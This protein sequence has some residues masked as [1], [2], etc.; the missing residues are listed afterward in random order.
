MEPLVTAAEMRECDALAIKKFRMPGVA[1]MENA[2]RGVAM[3]IEKHF[4]SQRG[5]TIFIFCGKGNNGGD[6]FVAGRHLLNCGA[7]VVIIV[8][9]RIR[10]VRGDAKIHLDVAKKIAS[11]NNGQ[12]LRIIEF[13]STQQLSRIGK[14]NIIVDALFG[15]GFSGEVKKPYREV[16]QW[17]NASG[18]PLVAVD[19]PS[20]VNA[21]NGETASIAVRASLTVTMGLK[22]IGLVVG[23]GLECTGAIVVEDIGVRESILKSRKFRTFLVQQRDVQEILPRR[24]IDAHKHSVGKVFVLAGS[25]GLTGAA[26][27]ASQAALRLGA[28]AVVLGTP[29]SVYPILAKKLTEVMVEPLEETDEG[30]VSFSALPA[31]EKMMT[32]ADVVVV[33][34]GL[35]RQLETRELVWR[36]VA[37]FNKPLLID[38]DGINALAENKSILKT[39]RNENVILTPHT[40][41]FSRLI[42]VPPKEIEH[43]RVG[44]ARQFA[45]SLKLTLVLKGAPTVTAT[46]DGDT[47]INS[48]GNPG[49]A[50]A[51]S[52]DVLAGIIASLWAQKMAMHEACYCGVFVHGLAG[53][54]AKDKYGERGML[55]TDI[56]AKSVEAIKGIEEFVVE[57][58]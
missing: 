33:G 28:G 27:M 21:D 56:L 36:I 37:Q 7:R 12:K 49:M 13:R 9:G 1:L 23:K 38:A 42:G 26:A 8:V 52:G 44:I 57:R 16:I 40:G 41:E 43:N 11:E 45:R 22:K 30:S 10:H 3:A 46:R 24:S 53:N 54:L 14:P 5:N 2:G 48:T 32:W 4:G 15:T 47:F 29:Q 50:T 18:V 19:I 34:P 51:G 39:R 20:G 6:G 55:A 58:R 17:V 25:R 35:S 31:I